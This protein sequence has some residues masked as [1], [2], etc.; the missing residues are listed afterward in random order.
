MDIHFFFLRG[1]V[2]ISNKSVVSQNM[3]MLSKTAKCETM[4]LIRTLPQ[5]PFI[6]HP[7]AANQTINRTEKIERKR[8]S[9][10]ELCVASAVVK[11]GG[12]TMTTTRRTSG[13]S[14]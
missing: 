8:L 14:D 4:P 11:T 9:S 7:T 5:L 13:S 1:D 12:T 10:L 3:P 6:Q 2:R